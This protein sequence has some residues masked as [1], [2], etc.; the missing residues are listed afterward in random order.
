M[1][2]PVI[3]TEAPMSLPEVKEELEAIKQRDKELTYRG[4]KTGEY[5]GQFSMLNAKKAKELYGAIEKIGVPRLKDIHIKKIIDTMPVTPNSVKV[6]LQGYTIT[7]K[8]EHVKQM[9]E[10]VASFAPKK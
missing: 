4:N 2:K 8:Q 10:A 6:V 9:A 3:I 7:V 5:L 1:V